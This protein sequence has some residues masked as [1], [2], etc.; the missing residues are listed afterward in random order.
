MER[1][2][3]EDVRKERERKL[4]KY[5]NGNT[6]LPDMWKFDRELKEG[7]GP[8]N[9]YLLAERLAYNK[10]MM[11]RGSNDSFFYDHLHNGSYDPLREDTVYQ[12]LQEV[13]EKYDNY[14]KQTFSNQG[15]WDAFLN[16]FSLKVIALKN[17][18]EKRTMRQEEYCRLEQIPLEQLCNELS[19]GSR[20]AVQA[21]KQDLIS[22]GYHIT[23]SQYP[24]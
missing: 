1:K 12:K 10:A 19:Q 21:H 17:K 24:S 15:L 18:L 22:M 9:G 5:P 20:E 6:I 16:K 3:L 13:M 2:T 7:H 11:D 23:A 4:P 14:S 8:L